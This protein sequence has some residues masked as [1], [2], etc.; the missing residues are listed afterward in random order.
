MTGASPSSQSRTPPP[1][2]ETSPQ[3]SSVSPTSETE[4]TSTQGPSGF[5]DGNKESRYA[6]ELKDWDESLQTQGMNANA[7]SWRGGNPGEGE[8][9]SAS[10][11]PNEQQQQGGDGNVSGNDPSGSTY[12][13]TGN[14]D[15]TTDPN[16]DRTESFSNLAAVIGT[17]LM[18]S[19]D[20][21][22]KDHQNRQV[23]GVSSFL[24]GGGMR[25]QPAGP[26]A[27]GIGGGSSIWEQKASLFD[28]SQGSGDLSRH[29]Q[30]RHTASRMIGTTPSSN[31]NGLSVGILSKKRFDQAPMPAL[32]SSNN[33]STPTV[34]S[35]LTS[36]AGTASSSFD[37][38]KTESAPTG[39]GTTST[40]F[41]GGGNALFSDILDHSLDLKRNPNISSPFREPLSSGDLFGDHP[42][43]G[44]NVGT[45]V[46]EPVGHGR[47]S[48]P[49]ELFGDF[50]SRAGTP[51]L[52]ELTRGIQHLEFERRSSFRSAGSHDDVSIDLSLHVSESELHRFCWDVRHSEP[53]RTL[54]IFR[55]DCVLMSDLRAT[56][57]A[58][59]VLEVFRTDFDERGVIF[60]GYYDIR[61]SI[62]AA[63]ELR[64]SLHRLAADDGYE[65][66]IDVKYCVPLN[67]SSA[68]DESVLVFSDL[69][70]S[71]KDDV[72]MSM[73]SSFGEVRSVK[74]Q[75]GSHFGS[76]LVYSYTVEFHSIQDAKQALLELESTQ[77]W[78]PGIMI[79]VGQRSAAER[80]R[81]RE[82]LAL[83]GRWRDGRRS[84]HSSPV[85]NGHIT[86]ISAMSGGRLTPLSTGHLSA[87]RL[88][89]TSPHV[90]TQWTAAHVPGGETAKP[91]ARRG[92]SSSISPS[93]VPTVIGDV[94]NDQS[95]FSQQ[96]H[97][98]Q[99][100][101]PPQ[102]V[103]GHDGSYSYAN[104]NHGG[105]GPHGNSYH[106]GHPHHH[107]SMMDHHGGGPPPGPQPTQQNIVSGPH[108][109]FVS[110]VPHRSMQAPP[111]HHAPHQQ[112]MQ[113]YWPP[114]HGHP[115]HQYHVPQGSYP[116]DNHGYNQGPP[117]QSN[118]PYYPHVVGNH[119]D[120]AVP[121]NGGGNS[122][123]NN[124]GGGGGNGGQ[125]GGHG[126]R[127]NNGHNYN[128]GGGNHGHGHGHNGRH[129]HH[130]HGN[131][132]SNNGNHANNGNANKSSSDDKDNGH[133]TLDIGTVE[134]G[135]DTRTSLMVRNIPN[136]YTQQ[137]LL[138]EFTDN[139]HG[140]GTID[141][142]YLPIDFKNKCNR[143]YA[144]VN[145]VDYRDIVA[146]HRQYFGQHWQVFNSDKICDIT[147]ARI[148]GKAG[149][150]KRFEN[151]V[152]MEKDDEY[153]PLVFESHGANKGQR[154]AFPNNSG[155]NNNN[156]GNSNN[157]NNHG[158]HNSHYNNNHGNGHGHGHG[159][160][161]HGHHNHHG[162]H[163][164]KQ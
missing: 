134:S 147:Y 161:H 111:P 73:L 145:F 40:G 133:L 142:F 86:P 2:F 157:N 74:R 19:M 141:F 123:N 90:P 143:G 49:P 92:L 148:Q 140:P 152:V 20:D 43:Y 151:S 23:T 98:H 31:S 115:S 29:R 6:G 76:N 122:P 67:S 88:T 46:T 103:V 102:F 75:A 5:T 61:S 1:G 127:R 121:G 9:G 164:N 65:T 93:G 18:E 126:S 70:P 69:P 42:S 59:G 120:P 33:G 106:G 150:L 8:N 30:S 27:A 95:M 137:M 56:C 24:A 101:G 28:S 159:H 105:D 91:R 48:A 112:H 47:N 163:H 160:R 97:G 100:P 107:Q 22:T 17:G 108:G 109:A 116:V 156:N 53:S 54:A 154:V 83:L 15:P 79:E 119:Q 14:T 71:I 62:Q 51:E 130:H 25:G 162:Q 144:F 64:S 113:Q 85:S 136:K 110:S 72:L 57:E 16:D 11:D 36:S 114:H 38:L 155:N 63:L 41:G 58:F 13:G 139:G 50:S 129:H 131:N 82:L 52:G 99:P 128:G 117:P 104:V 26:S 87:G 94:R 138:S 68:Q 21:S 132:G 37:N 12:N 149:M 80:Q 89:P 66:S 96:N 81:G 60:V 146:F 34:A 55:A 32:T 77:P 125:G 45:T 78:G 118:T 44:A 153:K 3:P 7:P 39:N 135:N 84:N 4:D 158:H 10:Q 35:T 124:N